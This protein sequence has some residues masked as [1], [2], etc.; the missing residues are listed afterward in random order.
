[1]FNWLICET[2]DDKG[3]AAV[4]EYAAKDDANVDRTRANERNYER[5]RNHYIKRIKYRTVAWPGAG[6][7]GPRV[8]IGLMTPRDPTGRSCARRAARR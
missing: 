5:T 2:N 3:N 4:Y 8:T 1:M 7:H 6:P